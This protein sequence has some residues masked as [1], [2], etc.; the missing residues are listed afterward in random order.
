MT[1]AIRGIGLHT[2]MFAVPIMLLLTGVS[3]LFASRTYLV[4]IEKVKES[5][6]T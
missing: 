2:A 6:A 1:E 5:A 4:D 3:L